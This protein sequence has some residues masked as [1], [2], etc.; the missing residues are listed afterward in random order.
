MVL[1]LHN[2]DLSGN[3]FYFAIQTCQEKYLTGLPVKTRQVSKTC[4]VWKS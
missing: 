3:P 4:R 1:V 2:P